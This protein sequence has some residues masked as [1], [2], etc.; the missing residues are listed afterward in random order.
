MISSLVELNE[1]IGSATGWTL[2]RYQASFDTARRHLISSMAISTIIDGGANEGQWATPL[3]NQFP[4]LDLVSFE[5]EQEAFT[6]LSRIAKAPNWTVINSALGKENVV[7]RLNVSSKNTMVSSIRKP[8][9]LSN[10]VYPSVVFD[11]QQ[12]IQVQRLD[13]FQFMRRKNL[14]LKLDVQGSEMDALAGCGTLLKN[15]IAIEL[16]TSLE[17]F[18]EGEVSHYEVVPWLMKQGFKPF[19]LFTP[20]L[21]SVGQVNYIDVL[22]I[23]D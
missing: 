8:T 9:A 12:R 4:S 7:S 11:A 3:R 19:S 6:K 17:A 14:F 10:E 15:V 5:P 1:R 23:R 18:Y 21:S 20:N 22:L 2:R 16:E 13:E